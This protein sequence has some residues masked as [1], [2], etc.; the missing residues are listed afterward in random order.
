[1]ERT[2]L[3]LQ[4]AAMRQALFDE[5]ILDKHFTYLENL[6]ENGNP[7]F[8]ED[9]TGLFFRDSAN[10][11]ATIERTL[12]NTP[13]DFMKLDKCFYQLKG[14]SGS[15]G[16]I[17]LKNEVNRTREYCEQGNLEAAK[18]AFQQLR[19]EHNILR[20]RLDSYLQLLRQADSSSDES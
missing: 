15:I 11:L 6:E 5:G 1:M 4:I 19:N 9:T 13:V 20:A 7:N 17:R 16:A 18:A 14:S 12:E 8:V 2:Q 3:L 10:M